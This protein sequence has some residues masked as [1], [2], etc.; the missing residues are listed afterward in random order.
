MEIQS[1]VEKAIKNAQ[2]HEEYKRLNEIKDYIDSYPARP[3]NNK[4]SGRWGI[5]AAVRARF[6][7]T[8]LEQVTTVKFWGN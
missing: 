4:I 5:N 3:N 8:G 7:D 6:G 2:D 1:K